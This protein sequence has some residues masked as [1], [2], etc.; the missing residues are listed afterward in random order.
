MAKPKKVGKLGGKKAASPSD[1]AAETTGGAGIE[2]EAAASSHRA[3][4]Q[5]ALLAV[6]EQ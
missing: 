4:A 5:S 1:E 6:L 3:D 2:G